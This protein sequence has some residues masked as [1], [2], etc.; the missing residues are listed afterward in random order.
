[1]FFRRDGKAVL[2]ASM[3]GNARL[4]EIPSGK[5]IEEMPGLVTVR[6][7]YLPNT[8]QRIAISGDGSRVLTS[9]LRSSES[10][11]TAQLWDGITGK[12]VGRRLDHEGMLRAVTLSQDGRIALTGGNDKTAR[13]W[14][15]RT[16][17]P[18]RSPLYHQDEVLAVALSLDGKLALT[19]SSDWTARIWDVATC[20]PL[21]DPLRHQKH[22]FSVNFLPHSRSVLTGGLDEVARV[23]TLALPKPTGQPIGQEQLDSSS[24]D[25]MPNL[26]TA[27]DG[28]WIVTGHDDG[29]A[30]VRDATTSIAN[31]PP[32]RNEYAVISVAISP[33]G[34]ILATGCTDGIARVWSARTRQQLGQT[35]THKGP[36]R[37]LA[38]SP[39]GQSVL[40]GSSDG[41]AQLWDA[42]SGMPIGPPLEHVQGVDSVGFSLD[43]ATLLTRT[44][45]GSIRRWKRPPEATGRDERF[46]LWTQVL[47]GAVVDPGGTIHGLDSS[48]WMQAKKR[49]ESL[50]GAPS[51]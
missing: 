42:L 47:T 46:V 34:E 14:D 30:Q 48:V 6:G 7:S 49:L 18:L 23:W 15:A 17:A 4:W 29:T 2:T 20:A 37:S 39:D 1:M 12:P 36:V 8:G 50:G 13:L 26:A 9:M 35:M 43:G 38:F 22:V 3:D 28:T 21:G 16:G 19:G 40:S 24:L 11:Q 32:L 51:R 33:N 10:R 31:G 5:L 41:T 27:P 44:D 25:D 45:I